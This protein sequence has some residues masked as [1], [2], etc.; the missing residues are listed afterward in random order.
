MVTVM[1]SGHG[2]FVYELEMPGRR[3]GMDWARLGYFGVVGY[4]I[5]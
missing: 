1:V 4:V 3:S 2:P 5:Y